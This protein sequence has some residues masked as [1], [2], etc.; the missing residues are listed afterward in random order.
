MIYSGIDE[1]GLGPILGPFCAT[2]ISIKSPDNPGSLLNDLNGTLFS[3]DDSKKIYKGKYGLKK[4]EKNVLAFYYIA[5]GSI[6][7]SIQEFIPTLKT[8]WYSISKP[9]PMENS[10]EEIVDLSNSIAKELEARDIQILG[11]KRSA[12]S[13]RDF[14]ILLDRFQNKSNAIQ[15]IISPLILNIIQNYNDIDLVIDKQ[16]GRKFYLDYLDDLAREKG[17]ILREENNTSLYNYS[18]GSIEFR[19]KAD[20]NSFPVALASMFSKYMREI[21]M[22]LFNSYWETIIPEIKRTAGYYVDGMRFL[23]DLKKSNKLPEDIDALIR[24]K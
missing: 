9:L 8:R 11:I 24:K 18:F 20:S 22:E 19:A 2:S 12:V 13:E 3:V 16:G 23:D 6:P 7:Q 17:S 15:K 21:S 5:T 10:L 1:A 4:L 14:N